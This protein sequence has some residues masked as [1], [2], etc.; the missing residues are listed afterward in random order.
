MIGNVINYLAVRSILMGNTKEELIKLVKGESDY[1]FFVDNIS[2]IM[3]QEDYI[4]LSDELIERVADLVHQYRFDYNKNKEINDE[5]NYIIGRLHDYRGMNPRR[6]DLLCQKW[7]DEELFYRGLSKKDANIARI[8]KMIALDGEYLYNMVNVGVEFSIDDILEYLSLLN[9]LLSRF[10]LVFQDNLLLEIA[11]QT[12]IAIETI[13][14]L[15]KKYLKMIKKFLHKL[16]EKYPEAPSEK[17]EIKYY[18]KKK[19]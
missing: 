12:C 9:L 10:P 3:Q 2:L 15:P 19:D 1:K 5:I 14:K 8:Y 13:P 11:K 18:L 6:K 16:K 17:V 7:F 4:L